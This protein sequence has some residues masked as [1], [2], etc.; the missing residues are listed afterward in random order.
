MGVA[1]KKEKTIRN[2]SSSPEEMLK[3]VEIGSE[4]AAQYPLY[5]PKVK[6]NLGVGICCRVKSL[7]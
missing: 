7:G 2:S 3:F 6:Q 1:K 5:G 4:I